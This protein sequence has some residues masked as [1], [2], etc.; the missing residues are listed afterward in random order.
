MKYIKEYKDQVLFNDL[1][2]FELEDSMKNFIE[3]HKSK[4][5]KIDPSNL[6]NDIETTEDIINNEKYTF[7]KIAQQVF[8]I[9]ESSFEKFEYFSFDSEQIFEYL[10]TLLKKDFSNIDINNINDDDYSNIYNVRD[11]IIMLRDNDIIEGVELFGYIDDSDFIYWLDKMGYIDFYAIYD[12]YYYNTLMSILH[13]TD[14]YIDIHRA[15]FIDK[16]YDKHNKYSGVGE[17]WSYESDGAEPHSGGYTHDNHLII[18]HA[19]VHIKNVNWKHTFYKSV[20][21]LSDEREIETLDNV[22]IELVSYE[23]IDAIKSYIDIKDKQDGKIL[24][25]MKQFYKNDSKLNSYLKKKA[26]DKYYIELD[27]PINLKIN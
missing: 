4:T 3:R 26:H 10:Y 6:N 1:R 23:L 7:E 16:D 18:L 25:T 15:I 13:E 2:P 14:E 9:D 19:K 8:D 27:E 24:K 17:F 22:T 5:E 12:T 20:Y 11:L 21:N